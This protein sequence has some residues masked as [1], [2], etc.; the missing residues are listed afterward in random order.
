MKTFND[1]KGRAWN[2][3]IDGATISRV[4][5]STG[6][7]NLGNISEGSPPLYQR[8]YN[9][10]ALVG[11]IVWELIAQQALAMAPPV[12]IGD[13]LK[14]LDGKAV[15]AAKTALMDELVFFF[16]EASPAIGSQI[17]AY[18]E[19]C[20]ACL[21]AGRERLLKIN[22]EELAKKFLASLP[23]IPGESSGSTPASSE[24]IPAT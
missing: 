15:G 5:S 1:K 2:I 7:I 21:K 20:N 10:L 12:M 13:F 8:I 24:S 4:L 17:K 16:L 23:L 9:D 18:V 22:P 6:D 11:R 3:E 14:E 19:T